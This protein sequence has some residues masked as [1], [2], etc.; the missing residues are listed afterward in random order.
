MRDLSS[1]RDE[2]PERS[3]F[4]PATNTITIRR[5]SDE[6][7][8]VHE[9]MHAVEEH[10]KEFLEA[11]REYFEQRTKGKRLA[12]L[13][14][15]MGD[16]SYEIDEIAYDVGPSCLTPYAFRDY[17]GDGYELMSMG[18]EMLYRSPSAYLRDIE[19]L[20]WVLSMMGRFGRK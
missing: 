20:K 9:L 14:E 16:A 6:L 5:G 10:D 2:S 8:I 19:M 17:G 4:D 11:E 1:G 13:R 3:E 18:V 15:L 12:R 7:A